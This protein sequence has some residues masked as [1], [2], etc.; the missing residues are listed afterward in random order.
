M[1]L[2]IVKLGGSLLTLPQLGNRLLEWLSN[3]PPAFSLIVV[4]GGPPVDA[5]RDLAA[6]HAYD[7]ELLHWLCIDLLDVSYRLVAAQLPECRQLQTADELQRV[8]STR[9]W[10]SA[11]MAPVLVRVAAFYDREHE[12]QL[13]WRLPHSWDTTSDSLAALLAQ[14]TG[15]DELVLLKSCPIPAP[16]SP[17]DWEELARRGVVDAAFTK[18]IAGL[19]RVRCANIQ[20]RRSNKGF[21]SA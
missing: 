15:A 7:E 5:I 9:D 2:R 13:P 11:R 16:H 12:P 14:L 3:E 6:V 10:T 17:G 19:K 21:F 20:A 18:T 1:H 4:G 8:L